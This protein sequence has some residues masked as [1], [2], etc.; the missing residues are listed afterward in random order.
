M[1]KQLPTVSIQEIP[2]PLAGQRKY[3]YISVAKNNSDI[4]LEVGIMAGDS[5]E[6]RVEAYSGGRA[7]ETPRA[8]HINGKRYVVESLAGRWRESPR[9]TG[10]IEDHFDVTL[11]EYGECE[12][13]YKH[14][15]DRW[16][17]KS[18]R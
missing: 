12:I 17:L 16:E 8:V 15:W 2:F 4:L 10:E 5:R 9:D 14:Q 3:H 7:N 1:R 11:A 13:V 18:K 6:I